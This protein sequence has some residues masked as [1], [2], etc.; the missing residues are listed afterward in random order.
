M[1]ITDIQNKTVQVDNYQAT[2]LTLKIDN[3][4]FRFDLIDKKEFN[5]RK[6]TIGKLSIYEEHPLLIDYN[7]NIVT[8]YIN[9]KPD[10][11]DNFVEA[12]KN[13][14]NE[15]TEGWRDWTY[16]IEERNINFKIGIFLNNV[17]NG[18][19]K[20]IEAPFS[21]TQKVINVCKSHNVATKTFE[22]ELKQDNFKIIFI[23]DNYVIAKEFRQH[24]N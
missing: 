6:G 2:F 15:I 22:N 20:L 7:E 24:S 10:N 4:L 1:K 12:F 23:A 21:I 9:S 16:Y 8:T 19:G 13:A 14:I 18:T 11:F 17:K 5:L 3:Q